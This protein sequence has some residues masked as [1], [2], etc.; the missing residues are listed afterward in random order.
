MTSPTKAAA[1]TRSA[2]SRSQP[3]LASPRIVSY[4]ICCCRLAYTS[5]S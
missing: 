1:S 2:P 5:L 3:T 4:P